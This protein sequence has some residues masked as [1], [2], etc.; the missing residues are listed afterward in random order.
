MESILDVRS[1]VFGEVIPL[2]KQ[3]NEWTSDIT[4]LE[5]I[6]D[7]TLK[8]KTCEKGLDYTD[9]LQQILFMTGDCELAYRMMEVMEIGL[10]QQ[11]NC[12]N[13]RMDHMLAVMRFKVSFESKPLFSTLISL[14]D[15]HWKNYIF[16][17]EVERSYVP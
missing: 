2:I 12:E 9:Y 7:E 11:K 5:S 6:F 13:A 14:G 4:N 15:I 17:R 3:A 10:Q 1:L 8:A 16:T